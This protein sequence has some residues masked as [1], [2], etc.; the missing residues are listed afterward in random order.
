MRTSDHYALHI[1]H[2][3]IST[4]SILK[5]L[6]SEKRRPVYHTL[7]VWPTD[8]HYMQKFTTARIQLARPL[9]KLYPGPGS[10][11]LDVVQDTAY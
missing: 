3:F 7:E 9:R 4:Y 2:I 1:C 8:K 6:K 11:G 5:Q 10:R